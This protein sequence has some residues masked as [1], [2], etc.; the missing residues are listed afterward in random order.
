MAS[1]RRLRVTNYRSIGTSVELLFPAKMP[2]VLVGENNAGKSNIVRALNLILGPFWP[3]NIEPDDADFHGR[4]RRAPIEIVTDFDDHDALGERFT[5]LT[6]RY[7]PGA[8]AIRQKPVRF[9]G[10]TLDGRQ[11]AWPKQT[12][13]DTCTCVVL[14]A[15]RKLS[16]HLGYS[17]KS[18]MLS[19][20]MHRF[21]RALSQHAATRAEL[22]D[23]FAKVKDAFGKIPEFAEFSGTLKSQLGGMLTSMTHRL[24]VDFEAYN[25]SNFFHALRLQAAEGD[26]PRALDEMGTGEQE[27]LAMAFAYAYAEAFH[28]GIVLVVEE[29]ESH[30]HPLAESWLARRLRELCSGGLQVVLTTHSPHFVDLLGLEGLALTTKNGGETAVA[31]KTRGELATYCQNTGAPQAQAATV[32]PFYAAHAT[33]EILE[34]FF[35]RVVV[36]VEG[37]TEA[38]ALPICLERGGLNCAKDGIAIISVSGKGNLSKWFRL[39]TLYEIPTYVIFDNDQTRDA[40][41]ARREGVLKALGIAADQWPKILAIGD[42]VINDEFAVFG[43]DF[44]SSMRLLFPEYATLEAKAASVGIDPESKPILARWVAEQLPHD[45][46]ASGWKTIADLSGRL[47]KLL[48]G[49]GPRVEEVPKAAAEDDDIPF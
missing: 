40:V 6:W 48:P 46:Q 10:R 47:R 24:E 21:H 16:Y 37:P 26:V 3:G 41:G 30:L 29:P 17:S 9:D 49:V 32:L 8:D 18:T 1:L 27:V 39:F 20:L 5:Q 2:V 4:A 12:D 15:D 36:L 44:E 38:L 28:G 45:P 13:R 42:V 7:D 14:E 11:D 31:Q 35:A 43:K 23:L 33:R 22:E 34:G 19:R 25:P